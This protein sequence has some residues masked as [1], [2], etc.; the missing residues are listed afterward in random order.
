MLGDQVADP[1]D[2]KG[3][4]LTAVGKGEV[5]LLYQLA[6]FVV[7]SSII[8]GTCP[9]GWQLLKDDLCGSAVSCEQDRITLSHQ[10]I[11][12]T[13]S[14]LLVDLPQILHILHTGHIRI[15]LILQYGQ[16]VIGILHHLCHIAG[17]KRSTDSTFS[18]VQYIADTT[19]CDG[20]QD[21]R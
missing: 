20:S 11:R 12:R 19:V 6:V 15:D 17:E 2:D 7:V 3:A 1:G 5:Q 21:Q 18:V 4:S 9:E 14:V 13:L 10:Q 8:L 16:R